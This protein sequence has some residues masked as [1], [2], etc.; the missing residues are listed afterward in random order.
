MPDRP[1]KAGWV[2]DRKWGAL[3]LGRELEGQHSFSMN[4][5][6]CAPGTSLGCVY[7]ALCMFLSPIKSRGDLLRPRL[8]ACSAPNRSKAGIYGCS[9]VAPLRFPGGSEPGD[10]T[11]SL[12]RAVPH[13]ASSCLSYTWGWASREEP[14]LLYLCLSSRSPGDKPSLLVSRGWGWGVQYSEQQPLSLFIKPS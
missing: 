8:Q 5:A 3:G 13:P 1:H 14:G 10:R 4:K 9:C 12:G 2:W 7:L 6:W 11:R